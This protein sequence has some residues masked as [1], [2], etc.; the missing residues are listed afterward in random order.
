MR[1]LITFSPHHAVCAD[2]NVVFEDLH[3]HGVCFGCKIST[4]TFD[5]VRYSEPGM[6]EKEVVAANAASGR[7][8]IRAS[9]GDEDKQAKPDRPVKPTVSD[10]TKRRIYN[11]YGR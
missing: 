10:E 1:N 3:Q 5:K 2:C 9:P 8:I 6:G 7:E 4:L 11:S